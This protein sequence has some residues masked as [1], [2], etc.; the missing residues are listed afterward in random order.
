MVRHFLLLVLLVFGCSKPDP[1]PT[2]PVE[3]VRFD[4]TSCGTREPPPSGP[5]VP[6]EL[7]DFGPVGDS[8][9]RRGLSRHGT[10][11]RRQQQRST[12]PRG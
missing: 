2:D 9:G 8:V 5:Q 7:L 1:A 6:P 10:L 12:R 4:P 3:Q 11:R